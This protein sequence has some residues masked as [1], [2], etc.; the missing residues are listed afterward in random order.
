MFLSRPKLEFAR[1]AAE[2]S[3]ANTNTNT[4]THTNT[5]KNKKPQYMF[6]LRPKLEFARS[7]AE[8]LF[9]DKRKGTSLFPSSLGWNSKDLSTIFQSLRSL[10]NCRVISFD[11]SGVFPLLMMSIGQ[12][13][14]LHL[15]S[16]GQYYIL[17]DW[18]KDV[19]RI[20]RHS[21]PLCK[22]WHPPQP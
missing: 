10:R 22:M 1:S 6:Q 11:S 2:M 12:I 17:F 20:V 19:K 15:L 13:Q 21:P 3:F 5:N 9:A 4:N 16:S 18:H 7:A 8:M 14:I